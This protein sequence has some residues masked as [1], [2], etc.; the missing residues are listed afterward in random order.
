M[1]KTT[2]KH[3]VDNV[4][5]FIDFIAETPPQTCRLSK[6]VMVGLRREMKG[7]RKSL[8]RGVAMHRTHVKT[9]KE[10]KVLSKAL[11]LECRDKAK[12]GIPQALGKLFLN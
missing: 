7:L 11:L 5:Q 9:S 8:K 10:E 6:T 1:T 2:I 4:A 12:I 3:Y